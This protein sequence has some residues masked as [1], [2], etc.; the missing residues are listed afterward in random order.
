MT[1]PKCGSEAGWSGPVYKHWLAQ[2]YDC[3]PTRFGEHLD[4]TCVV[5]GYVRSEPTLD[6]P[7]PTPL[8]PPEP[9]ANSKLKGWRWSVFGIKS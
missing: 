2:G 9:P 7:P 1:C 5:C 3:I 6:A 8:A 4:F